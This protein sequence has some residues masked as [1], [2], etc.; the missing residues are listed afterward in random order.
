[1][2]LTLNVILPY[3]FFYLFITYVN[4]AALMYVFEPELVCQSF[5]HDA[6]LD[7]I[8]EVD[9]VASSITI[10]HTDYKLAKLGRPE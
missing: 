1:M 7:E 6:G 5:Q 2:T 8:I 4:L 10:K 9:A 3:F